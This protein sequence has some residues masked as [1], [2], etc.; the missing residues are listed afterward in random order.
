M[1]LLYYIRVKIKEKKL[2]INDSV[3]SKQSNP[4][5]S[6]NRRAAVMDALNR[7]IEI[8][9]SHNEPTFDE[10]MEKALNTFAKI[11]DINRIVIYRR[12]DADEKKRLKQAYRWD[13]DAGGLTVESLNLPPDTAAIPKWFDIL[14]LN[15][16]VDQQLCDMPAEQADFMN[17]S[18]VGPAL[19]VPVFARGWFWGGVFF[20]D[21]ADG[22]HFDGDCTDLF[23]S[24]ARI[25]ANAIISAEMEREVTTAL[26]EAEE[27]SR[28]KSEFLSRVSHEML[29]PMNAIAGMTQIAK[30]SGSLEKTTECLNKLEDASRQLLR[31]INDLLDI[32][33]KREDELKLND[34]P[35][36]F[37]AMFGGILKKTDAAVSKKQQ[38]LIYGIDRSMPS[39]FVGDEKRLANVIDH[40]LTNAVKFTPEHGEIRIDVRVTEEKDGITGL[41]FEISDNG[42]G[43]SQEHQKE[44]FNIFEQVDGSMTRK[45]GGAGLGLPIAK[46]ITEMMGG[47]IQVESEPGK[48]SKFT[49]TCKLRKG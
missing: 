29:T 21:H 7:A 25:C 8:F 37:N 16:C 14:Q 30:R 15:G 49:F 19:M 22:R 26:F 9:C 28:A 36:D 13:A 17:I 20:Q 33:G 1:G 38:T 43:I 24:M 48:G 44:I 47:D 40:L 45:H 12:I 31:L 46:R 11:I 3:T 42:I 41:K 35:F 34:A 23:L 5:D 6:Y 27:A 18:C 39:S 4:F 10:V 32:S 2:V